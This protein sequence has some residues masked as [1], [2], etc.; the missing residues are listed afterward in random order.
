MTLILGCAVWVPIAIW[1]VSLIHWMIMGEI[2]FISGVTGIWALIGLGYLT[3]KPPRPELAYLSFAVV[4]ISLIVYPFIRSALDRR[5]LRS[6]DI[7]SVEKAYDSLASRPN[8]PLAKFKLARLLYGMGMPGHA[9]V[10]AEAALAYLPEQHF[11]E[12]HKLLK[13]WKLL[14]TKPD[15][16]RPIPCVECSALNAPG[17]IHCESCGAPFLLDRLRGK[18][19]PNALGRKLI[20]VWVAMVF[21]VV[22]IPAASTLPPLIAMAVIILL[23]AMVGVTLVLAFRPVSKGATA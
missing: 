7:S 19:L 17:L 8:N 10:I 21:G 22:G 4:L 9:V 18:F 23:L 13:R 3:I 1:F 12:E 11:L 14:V 5:E 16:F 20:A 6:I 15:L 2:E